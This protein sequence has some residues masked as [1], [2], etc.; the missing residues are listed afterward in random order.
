MALPKAVTVQDTITVSFHRTGSPKVQLAL[1]SRL[2]S[3]ST[4]QAQLKYVKPFFFSVLSFT[5]MAAR[6]A[7]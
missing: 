6:A 1:G 3:W 7:K 5:F 4:A 2:I